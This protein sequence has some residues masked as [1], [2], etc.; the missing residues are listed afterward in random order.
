MLL[1]II[2][3]L[4]AT[5]SPF[6]GLIFWTVN[7][8]DL[9]RKKAK[10][11][12]IGFA[13]FGG[14]VIISSF[15]IGI[16]FL[17]LTDAL[18]GVG[19][20]TF[21]FSRL[22]IKKGFRNAFSI[23]ALFQCSYGLFR[24]YLLGGY[25]QQTKDLILS[26]IDASRDLLQNYPDLE[27]EYLK[28]IDTYFNNIELFWLVPMIFALVMGMIFTRKNT[29]IKF[30]TI[31]YKLPDNLVYVMILGIIMAIV[32][33]TRFI[34]LPLTLTFV[35]LLTVQGFPIVWLWLLG[36]TFN[37]SILRLLTYIV[38]LINFH[39]FIM[40]SGIVGLIDIWFNLK[41]GVQK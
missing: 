22:Y 5:I 41:N 18:V 34:G 12:N 26:Q 16:D 3:S 25:V 15:L 28:M 19:L 29:L 38:I 27:A 35:A 17:R 4:V 36:S 39:I 40:I 23:F 7:I 24:K 2:S 10:D 11:V 20:S 31:A 1:A 14:V 33:Q 6:W 13:I 30:H 32:E 21:L 37:N 8:C 9:L